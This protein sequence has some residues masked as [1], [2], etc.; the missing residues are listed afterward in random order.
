MKFKHKETN[1]DIIPFI[2]EFAELA[3]RYENAFHNTKY[4][5]LYILKTHNTKSNLFKSVS[6]SKSYEELNKILEVEKTQKFGLVEKIEK[7]KNDSILDKLD[8]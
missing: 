7:E 8:K 2:F 4:N 3:Q 1:I 5:I 6:S